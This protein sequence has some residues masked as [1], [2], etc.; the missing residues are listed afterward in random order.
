MSK[1]NK[2]AMIVVAV[3]LVAVVVALSTLLGLSVAN[4]GVWLKNAEN[5][6]E[7]ALFDLTENVF[8]AETKLSKMQVAR[9]VNL[10]QEMLL[11]V[12]MNAFNANASL[13]HLAYK[14]YDLSSLTK[15]VNQCGDYCQQLLKK[16]DSGQSITDADYKTIADMRYSF[17][18]LGYQLTQVRQRVNEGSGKYIMSLG[19]ISQEFESGINEIINT[20]EYPSLIYDGAFSDSLF[21]KDPKG[22]PQEE[23]SQTQAMDI[24]RKYLDDYEL[25]EIVA[26]G[27]SNTKIA[28]FM[29]SF[30]TKDSENGTIKITKRGGLLEL[31]DIAHEVTSPTLSE[32]EALE[33][34]RQYCVKNNVE[35]QEC[36]WTSVAGS[37]LYVNMCCKIGDVICYLDMVKLK[38]S[39]QSGK[40]IG[41]EGLNY[42]YNHCARTID[43]P[44]LTLEQLSA[45][46]FGGLEIISKKL[47]LIPLDN[48]QE[49]L[50][51]EVFG[52]IGA[53]EFFIY[54]DAK[55]GNQ[56]KILQVIDSDE[57]RL[58][59]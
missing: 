56:V 13:T 23:V 31:M 34:A 38:V 58:T 24:A 36:V 25:K 20:A 53:V 21:D 30:V 28:S 26:I 59:A 52:H 41:F 7:Q 51:F 15:F 2:V 8:N 57:G 50:T 10:Q 4:N 6:F 18:N 3:V 44:T 16:L 49:C 39:L 11:D 29:F 55:N 17:M 45:M 37:V 12:T 9:S 46:D 43:A 54:V 14:G 42:I 48:G 27:E 1:K 32:Q 33:I 35:P 22:L 47:C 19:K 40:V 5:G